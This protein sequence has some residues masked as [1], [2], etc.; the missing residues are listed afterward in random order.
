MFIGIVNFCDQNKV[1][2]KLIHSLTD[3]EYKVAMISSKMDYYEIIKNSPIKYWI[4]SSFPKENVSRSSDCAINMKIF[5]LKTKS[6]FMIGPAM[7]KVMLELKNDYVLP[8]V[9]KTRKTR[10]KKSFWRPH[11]FNTTSHVLFRNM[12]KNMKVWSADRGFDASK[13][14]GGVK[15]MN[16]YDGKIMTAAYKNAILTQYYPFESD[17]GR[18]II[19]N[20]LS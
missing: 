15:V 7:E 16:Q 6:F 20:W 13:V 9:N 4:F 2:T 5:Q 17:D 18:R 8:N 14:K 10:K 12:K 1:P 11:T 3:M 19:L